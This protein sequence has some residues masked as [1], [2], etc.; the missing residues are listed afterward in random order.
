MK[1]M[2]IIMKKFLTP[3]RQLIPRLETCSALLNLC[4]KNMK[5]FPSLEKAIEKS[6]VA[7][8][9]VVKLMGATSTCLRSEH[10]CC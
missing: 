6:Y 3:V 9:A 4:K 1:K 2:L 5:K 7:S 8:D 10:D